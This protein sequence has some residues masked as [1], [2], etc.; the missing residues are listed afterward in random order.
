MKGR[1][2]RQWLQSP[3]HTKKIIHPVILY[4]MG[5]VLQRL[6][7][8]VKDPQPYT[9]KAPPDVVAELGADVG[10]AQEGAMVQEIARCPAP[11]A[12]GVLPRAP[13]VQVRH[14][15][16]LAHREP[17]PFIEVK[18]S[19][20]QRNNLKDS[21]SA[22]LCPEA[23]AAQRVHPCSKAPERWTLFVLHLDP[24]H[25]VEYK[26][27]ASGWLQAVQTEGH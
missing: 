23:C 11:V 27:S 6:L 1:C 14:Q 24:G 18:S 2:H 10:G 21:E 7:A 5:K 25:F 20:S 9:L 4:K 26:C 22:F 19:D 17:A 12:A 16:P 3:I 8:H 15:I 13:H